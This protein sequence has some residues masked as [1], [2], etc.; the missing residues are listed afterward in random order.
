VGQSL[1]PNG[2]R[3]ILDIRKLAHLLFEP[4]AS[5]RTQQGQAL[6]VVRGDAAE[7]RDRWLEAA[8]DNVALEWAASGKLTG[9]TARG[10]QRR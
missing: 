7:L 9:D 1:L 6:G 8:R 3:A 2:G 4:G 5:A 10:I